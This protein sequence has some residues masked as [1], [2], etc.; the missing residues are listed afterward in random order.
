MVGDEQNVWKDI[1][2]FS[3]QPLA[4][5]IMKKGNVCSLKVSDR[6]FLQ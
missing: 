2:E 6:N 4:V 3:E 5:G 1:H